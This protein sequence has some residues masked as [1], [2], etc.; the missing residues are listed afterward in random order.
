MYAW[1]C[2]FDSCRQCAPCKEGDQNYCEGPNSWLA[3]WNGPM[4]PAKKAADEKNHYGGDTFGG[5]SDVLVVAEDFSLKIPAG[6]KPEATAPLLC[7]G[8]YD[9]CADVA[10]GREAGS[11]VSIVGFGG[12]GA[13]Q[14]PRRDTGGAGLL[15]RARHCA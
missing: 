7:A 1:G 4:V 12:L 5:Y 9:V 3:T 2:M 8:Y 14:Q 11:Q 10:V 6:L 13:H 15:R